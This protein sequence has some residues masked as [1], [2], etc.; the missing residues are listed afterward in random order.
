M[1]RPPKVL[2]APNLP[3]HLP[4]SC[5][6]LA[7]EGAGSWFNIIK[8]GDNYVITRYSPNGELECENKFR[9]D[10]DLELNDIYELS[11]PSHCAKVTAYQNGKKIV[12]NELNP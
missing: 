10:N 9:V 2:V 6:W 4:A 7:G 12:F 1:K 8:E 3:K 11:Y 5:K